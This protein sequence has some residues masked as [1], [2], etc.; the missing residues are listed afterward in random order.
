VAPLKWYVIAKSPTVGVVELC[1]IMAL[2][3]LLDADPDHF[4]PDD[5]AKIVAGFEAAL[6]ALH[7]TDRKALKVAKIVFDAAKQGELDPKRL[8]DI[9]VKAF[10]R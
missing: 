4:R 6:T 1:G 7:I 2:Q 10:P 9:A 3:A 8:R 5:I